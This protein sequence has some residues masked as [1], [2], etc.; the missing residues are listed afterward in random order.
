MTLYRMKYRQVTASH[1]RE[2]KQEVLTIPLYILYHVVSV[3]YINW[4]VW[5][6]CVWYPLLHK[7]L[8]SVDCWYQS[9][10]IYKM[11]KTCVFLL[12]YV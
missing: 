4:D 3:Y 8:L 11:Y 10:F 1:N 9:A 6:R 5:T 2:I 7:V 12:I